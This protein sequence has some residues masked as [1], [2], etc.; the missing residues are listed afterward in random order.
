M[1]RY[2]ETIPE[3]EVKPGQTVE[4]MNRRK[5]KV[6]PWEPGRVLSI[7]WHD[8]SGQGGFR[9]WSYRVRTQRP[10]SRGNVTLRVQ[11]GE[12]RIPEEASGA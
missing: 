3:P 6:D 11:A 8:Y 4:V 9:A 2:T 7:H 5:T 10:P 1:S 12:V